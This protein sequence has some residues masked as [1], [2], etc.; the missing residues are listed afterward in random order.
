MSFQ[1][2]FSSLRAV[3]LV[4]ALPLSAIAG[5]PTA[6]KAASLSPQNFNAMYVFGDSLSDDGNLFDATKGYIPPSP[7][8]S[9]GRFSNGPVWVDYLAQYLGLTSNSN[10]NLAYGGA[11][12]GNSNVL[13]DIVPSVVL[14]LPGL[15]QQINNF[16]K[17]NLPANPDAL[18]IVWAGGNDYIGGG[19]TNAAIPVGN[20][21][22]A[23]TSLATFGAKNIMVVNLPDLGKLPDTR[24][25]SNS[26]NLSVLTATHNSGLAASLNGLSQ[27]LSQNLGDSINIIPLDANSLFDRVIAN[28]SE[29]GLR[30]VTEACLD[31]L[32]ACAVN[33][34]KF[35]FWDNIHPTTTAHKILGKY[36][37]SVLGQ[38]TEASAIAS[39]QL[40]RQ[41]ASATLT[42]A[43]VSDSQESVPEPASTFGILAFG[44]LGAGL[45]L[46]RQQTKAS[47]IKTEV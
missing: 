45:V 3:F 43:L 19:V 38:Q 6:V 18:Y 26:A 28:P 25:S 10:I 12:T 30:N 7:V 33:A 34:D 40:L 32:F 44:A 39:N 31:K 14:N 13:N 24:T 27:S 2:V 21:S 23:V 9:D 35:L 37:F 4:S 41:S 11:T 8:Y 16:K 36:A 47:S 42:P 29:F 5:L 1:K 46:K 17:A 20:L 15:Q 22:T